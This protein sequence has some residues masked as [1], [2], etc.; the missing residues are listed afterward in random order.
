M[1][2]LAWLK[3]VYDNWLEPDKWFWKAQN[4]LSMH[5]LNTHIQRVKHVFFQHLLS[6]IASSTV[7]L[8][9]IK[10]HSRT[11]CTYDKLNIVEQQKHW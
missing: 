3:L 11:V 4:T 5:Y 10:I 6:N 2:H 8:Q 1:K 7:Q 9:H